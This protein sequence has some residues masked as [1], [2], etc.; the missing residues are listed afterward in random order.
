MID[1]Y[2][3]RSFPMKMKTSVVCVSAMIATLALFQPCSAQVYSRRIGDNGLWHGRPFGSGGGYASGYSLDTGRQSISSGWYSGG[4][5]VWG[6]TYH[7]PYSTTHT[8]EDSF[9]NRRQ[10]VSPR[11]EFGLDPADNPAPTFRSHRRR[12]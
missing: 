1:T 11:I 6:H 8:W 2:K 3:P 12:R 4:G 5:Q 10:T 7:G 9:G